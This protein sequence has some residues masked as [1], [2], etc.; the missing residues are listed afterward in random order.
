MLGCSKRT[1][2]TAHR[3][4]VGV[5]FGP[6]CQN[7]ID[8]WFNCIL[9]V[10]CVFGEK[11]SLRSRL[12]GESWVLQQDEDPVRSQIDLMLFFFKWVKTKSQL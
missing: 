12:S 11:R 7:K 9:I 2:S 1:L 5:I 8:A 6:L 3:S 4:P 10:N